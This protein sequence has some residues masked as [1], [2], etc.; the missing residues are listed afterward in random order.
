MAKYSERVRYRRMK[1]IRDNSTVEGSGCWSWRTREGKTKKQVWYRGQYISVGRFA[2][3]A[4]LRFNLDSSLVVCHSC[5][6]PTCVNP[7]HLFIG[8]YSDNTQDMIAKGRAG[9]QKDT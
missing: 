4:F 5:D 7:D 6:N 3:S 9:W 8:T 2:A 1:K